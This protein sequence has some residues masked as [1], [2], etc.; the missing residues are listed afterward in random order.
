MP[1]LVVDSNY[2][3]T[4]E[5]RTQNTKRRY[6]AFISYSHKDTG[7]A[8]WLHRELEKYRVDRDLVGRET[9]TGKIPQNLRPIFNDRDD[10]ASGHSLKEATTLALDSSEFLIVICSPRSAAS[11]H[12]NEEIRLFKILG[13]SSR[14]IPIIID[15]EPNHPEL[16][17]FPPALK[18]EVLSDGQVSEIPVEPVAADARE[19]ADGREVAKLKVIA[20]LLGV[21][22]DEIRRRAARAARTRL[23]G[24]GITAGA[25]G[26]LA[27]VAGLAAWI[28]HTRAIEAEQRLDWALETAGSITSKTVSFKNRFGVPA[29]VLSDLLQE[30]ERLLGRLTQQGVNS[31]ELARREAQLYQALSNGN[32]DTGNTAKALLQAK[33]AL[34]K[35]AYFSARKDNSS[36]MGNDIAWAR[37][38]IGSLL[39]QQNKHEDAKKE[40]LE[41][42]QIFKQLVASEPRNP[43]WQSGLG[44]SLKRLADL[45]A[46]QG[47]Q[48]EAKAALDERIAI[49]RKLLQLYPS[50][51]P[52]KENLA[53]ALNDRGDL[54]LNSNEFKEA[55]SLYKEALS[56]NSSLNAV[57]PANVNWMES[58][59]QSQQ[60]VGY[61]LE[62]QGNTAEA[63][64][65]YTLA[66]EIRQKLSD[67]DPTDVSKL[68]RLAYN[69]SLI[70]NIASATGNLQKAESSFAEVVRARKKIALLDPQDSAEKGI[71]SVALAQFGTAQFYLGHMSAALL[72]FEEAHTLCAELIR[73]DPTNTYV[74]AAQAINL[75]LI[76]IIGEALGDQA[77]STSA[78]EEMVKLADE[79]VIISPTNNLYAYQAFFSRQ[80]LA[81]KY[82]SQGRPQEALELLIARQATAEQRKDEKDV[83][84][85][86][87][88]GTYYSE[89]YR[90]NV[91]LNR[92]S[93]ALAAA[94]AGLE[95]TKRWNDVD[96][97]S[98]LAKQ[99]VATAY[100]NVGITNRFLRKFDEARSALSLGL[101]IRKALVERDS[102]NTQSKSDLAI[103]W[104]RL[105]D[106][107]WDEGNYSDALLAEEKAVGIRLELCAIDPANLAFQSDLAES[108]TKIASSLERLDRKAEARKSLESALRTR[109]SLAQ[110]QPNRADFA[111]D[112]EWTARRLLEFK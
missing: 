86:N 60:N 96:K 46:V 11:L 92:F 8:K 63:V 15:G 5:L 12:V 22:L 45:L 28:A 101:E 82:R 31:P 102:G 69:T 66:R 70:G 78:A 75:G 74:K 64:D 103:S 14:I 68:G 19:I 65:L 112:V 25:M 3:G 93:D 17:C 18:F 108:Y 61:S 90:V 43:Q 48:V 76:G 97:R 87:A 44:A 49:D 107:H 34:D 51:N 55:H 24:L 30:V 57:D 110:S 23:I 40:F 47:N 91:D 105:N 4:D 16:E 39:K 71:L 79:L 20:G 6:R 88:V 81:I 84:W 33:L 41:A 2:L 73:S 109:Q 32:R 52:Y 85:L 95:I 38:Q 26:I 106:L 37:M 27:I 94:N 54:N 50:H 77:R 36:Q 72:T 80:L 42:Q 99:Q 67:L 104:S 21:G 7:W 35:L 10:F 58:F 9:A 83:N 56:I 89:L 13:R 62:R 100:T 98:A 59:A 29:P 53:S 111:A 1:R